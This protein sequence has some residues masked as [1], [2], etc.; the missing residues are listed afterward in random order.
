MINLKCLFGFHTGII[1]SRY[2][3]KGYNEVED[4]IVVEGK[5][6]PGNGSITAYYYM[7]CGNCGKY[8]KEQKFSF[9]WYPKG[10][11]G[12]LPHSLE[13]CIK[14]ARAFQSNKGT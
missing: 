2:H 9:G 3:F 1:N 7:T 4:H 12:G 10:T 14:K 13:E 8:L 5:Y 6:F 11:C